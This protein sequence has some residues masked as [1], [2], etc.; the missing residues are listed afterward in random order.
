M[1]RLDE[2]TFR[3]VIDAAPLVSIDLIAEREGK[4]LLG[5]R[6]NRPARGYFFTTGGRIL[7]N[8]TIAHAIDRIANVELGLDRLPSSP[9]FIGVFEHFYE[10]SVFEGV[11]THYVN[12]GYRLDV[13]AL[14]H[15]PAD[16]HSEYIWLTIE[17]LMA[18]P[19]VHPYVKNYFKK[20]QQ[21]Q[22]KK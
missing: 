13:G 6:K 8:E 12:L 2:A 11:S 16:Q 9:I 10:D 22:I 17:E 1:K 20:E 7:K 4:I 21:W 3:C 18:S 15:L 14:E 19:D 5:R